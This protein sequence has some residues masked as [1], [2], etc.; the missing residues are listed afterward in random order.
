MDCKSFDKLTA[1]FI[2]YKGEIKETKDFIRHFDECENCRKDFESNFYTYWGL[3]MLNDPDIDSYNIKDE[4]KSTL[5]IARQKIKYDKF[6]V[7]GFILV[8]ILALAVLG[9]FILKSENLF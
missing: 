8:V 3:K 6:V 7:I 9:F 1:G 4:M 5:L 2:K